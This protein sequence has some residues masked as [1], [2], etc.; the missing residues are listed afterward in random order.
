MS[1]EFFLCVGAVFMYRNSFR[2]PGD[3]MPHPRAYPMFHNKI[4]FWMI[5]NFI[6]SIKNVFEVK[7][8]SGLIV[9]IR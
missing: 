1:Q 3:G 8:P 4:N 6:L 5:T 9:E 7:I 2:I